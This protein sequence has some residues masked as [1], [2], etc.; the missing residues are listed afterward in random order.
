MII[1]QLLSDIEIAVLDVNQNYDIPEKYFGIG[2]KSLPRQ[3]KPYVDYIKF[4]GSSEEFRQHLWQLIQQRFW[5]KR[6]NRK[7]VNGETV[8]SLAKL[9]VK[10]PK[11][12]KQ[13]VVLVEP[14]FEEHGKVLLRA[15]N[16]LAFIQS[17]QSNNATPEGNQKYHDILKQFNIK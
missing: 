8:Y 9:A 3:L 14:G 16:F 17:Y 1:P 7:F 4:E 2:S 5:D 15:A 6:T 13:P 12:K 11:G 10:Y